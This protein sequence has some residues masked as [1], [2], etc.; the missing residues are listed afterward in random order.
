M[1]SDIIFSFSEFDFLRIFP[2]FRVIAVMCMLMLHNILML[3]K[4]K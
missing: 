3:L 4:K 2:V 1:L